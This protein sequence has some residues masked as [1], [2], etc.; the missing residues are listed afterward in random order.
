MTKGELHAS[1]C[2]EKLVLKAFSVGVVYLEFRS[3][4]QCRFWNTLDCGTV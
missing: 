3:N 1:E 2:Y 4:K